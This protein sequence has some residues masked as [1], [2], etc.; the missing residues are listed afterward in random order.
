MTPASS[1][2]CSIEGLIAEAVER[3]E[4]DL[5][6]VMG[7]GS[8][9]ARARHGVAGTHRGQDVVTALENTTERLIGKLKTW[10]GIATG[11]TRPRTATS[12]ASSR[13][14]R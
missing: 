2:P 9:T 13:A 11:T 12:S 5:S 6:V 10:R 14:P 7:I 3:G 1:R 4:V 8:T